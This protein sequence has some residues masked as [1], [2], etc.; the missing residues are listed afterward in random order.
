MMDHVKILKRALMITMNYRAM[1]VFGIILALTA[2]RGGG[3]GGSGGS[4][5]SSGGG[6]N[7]GVFPPEWDFDLPQFPSGV[8]STW[9]AVGIALACLILILIIVGV[10]ARYV[11]ETALI[12]MTERYETSEEKMGV[13]QGFRLGWSNAALRLFLIDLLFGL[14]GIV[15]FTLLLLVAA[16]PLLVWLTEST[17]ARTIGTVT[18]S[19]LIM[20]LIFAT[21]M[22]VLALS[23]L[24]QFFRRACVLEDLGVFDAIRRGYALVRRRLGDVLILALIMFALGLAWLVAIIPVVIMLALAAVVAGGLPALLAWA[25]ASQVGEGATPWVAAAVVGTPIFLLVIGAPLAFLGG[26]VETFKSN[27]WTLAYRD[28]VA[29]DDAPAAALPPAVEEAPAEMA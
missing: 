13:R 5:G 8:V 16:V 14:G 11:S 3:G 12:R 25:I 22:F 2:G 18:A 21:I 7:G 19:G 15:V 29:L 17:V 26:L 28:L 20:L 6:S 10:I 27:T 1:W 9:L 4:S 23:L 24:V